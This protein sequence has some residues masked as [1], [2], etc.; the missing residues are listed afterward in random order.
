MTQYLSPL[1]DVNEIDLRG[2]IQDG[3]LVVKY[4]LF[5]P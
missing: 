5:E 4:N 2:K 1:V 3:E